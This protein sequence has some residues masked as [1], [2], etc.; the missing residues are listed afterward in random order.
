MKLADFR[1]IPD[2]PLTLQRARQPHQD[3][4]TIS[5]FLYR[6]RYIYLCLAIWA[7]TVC[8]V[9]EKP[10]WAPLDSNP[11]VVIVGLALTFAGMARVFYSEKRLAN[12][13]EL[14][15]SVSIWIGTLSTGHFAHALKRANEPQFIG[16]CFEERI[17]EILEEL[18]VIL[19]LY[20][21]PANLNDT[22][23]PTDDGSTLAHETLYVCQNSSQASTAEETKSPETS[24]LPVYDYLESTGYFPTIPSSAP[25]GISD[26]AVNLLTELAK[27]ATQMKQCDLVPESVASRLT[28][29]LLEI[30]TMLHELA[31][32]LP[33]PFVISSFIIFIDYGLQR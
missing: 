10:E 4:Y 19:G 20:E 17:T 15:I 11:L 14:W 23:A 29:E 26:D 33:S 6:C 8:T 3:A 25:P 21:R 5:A 9:F 22:T 18:V 12:S 28:D 16:H 24:P 27:I 32:L 13:V 1:E 30:Q 2:L 31:W 7:T